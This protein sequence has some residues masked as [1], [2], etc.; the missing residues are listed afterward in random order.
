MWRKVLL[1]L[2]VLILMPL[3]CHGADAFNFVKVVG[4]DT[5][6]HLGSAISGEKQVILFQFNEQEP[7]QPGDYFGKPEQ[8]S[9]GKGVVK[10]ALITPEGQLGDIRSIRV[11]NTFWDIA[12]AREYLYA[13][14]EKC[15]KGWLENGQKED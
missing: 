10:V 5:K 12:K 13:V 1:I 2:F 8:N 14:Q 15:E 11:L 3:I 9:W 6:Y 4:V 7:F